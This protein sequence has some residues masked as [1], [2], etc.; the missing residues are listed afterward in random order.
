[1]TPEDGDKLRHPGAD[2]YHS[3]FSGDEQKPIPKD[4]ARNLLLLAK[5]GN[6]RMR[7]QK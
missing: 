3:N 4:D 6:L 1:M 7:S 5:L 2:E